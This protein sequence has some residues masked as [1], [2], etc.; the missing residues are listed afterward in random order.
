M[1]C[2]V[3]LKNETLWQQFHSLDNEMIIT[4]TGRRMFPSLQVEIGE[5]ERETS[6][7]VMVEMVPVSR[8]RFKYSTSGGWAPAG[9]E[10]A[11]SPNRMYIH[12][13]SPAKGEYWM[14]QPVS[15]ARMK[16]TNTSAAP[17]GQVVLTSMHKYQPRI[18]IAKTTEPAAFA[19]S[20]N[21]CVVF[22]ETQFVAVTAYQNERITQ[23][24]ID[25]NPF[26]KGFRESGQSKC[27]RKRDSTSESETDDHKVI[28][29]DVES[30]SPP[31]QDTDNSRRTTPE[32]EN[33]GEAA[34]TD[35]PAG[36][37]EQCR[38]PAFA[39]EPPFY[40]AGTLPYFHT[41][42]PMPFYPPTTVP[43]YPACHNYYSNILWRTPLL[44]RHNS[45]SLPIPQNPTASAASNNHERNAVKTYTDFTIKT[46]LGC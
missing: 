6:Y 8:C 46:I 29:I 14:S 42:A 36:P 16:L 22:P 35:V 23:L 34:P 31:P 28:K 2:S 37:S 9:S 32:L 24:K 21:S 45:P 26:A 15:F 41:T 40:A 12:P 44:Y 30:L 3:K 39:Y 11:Q 20:P 1:K 43:L 10:E 19:W 27:K 17:L 5:L 38:Y 18:I 25:N 33:V 4:K 7:C 13:E